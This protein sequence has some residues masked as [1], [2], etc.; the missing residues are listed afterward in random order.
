MLPSTMLPA[1]AR[2]MNRSGRSPL[3]TMRASSGGMVMGPVHH[4]K[5]QNILQSALATR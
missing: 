3:W 1:N 2:D 5:S 4:V